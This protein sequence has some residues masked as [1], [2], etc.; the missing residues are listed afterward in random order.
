MAV[1]TAPLPVC[2][3]GWA[4]PCVNGSDRL[5]GSRDPISPDKRRATWTVGHQ[6]RLP[7]DVCGQDR[8]VLH[9][10]T[11]DPQARAN[12][13]TSGQATMSPRSGDDPLRRPP[14]QGSR[15]GDGHDPRQSHSRGLQERYSPPDTRSIKRQAVCDAY[16]R[17]RFETAPRQACPDP[18]GVKRA[19]LVRNAPGM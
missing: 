11:G 8:L 18:C 13:K 4:F 3:E 17:A 9:S 10:L 2:D 6:A 14:V 16:R 15:G 19:Q 5:P 1:N 7:V 12:D